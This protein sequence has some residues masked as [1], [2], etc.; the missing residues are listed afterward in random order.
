MIGTNFSGKGGLSVAHASLGSPGH[1]AQKVCAT[2]S[3]ALAHKILFVAMFAIF[4]P[5]AVVRRA[6]PTM[7]NRNGIRRSIFEEAKISASTASAY[8][9]M[10]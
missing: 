6:M 5:V 4:L 3:D 2:R 1:G 7:Q 10:G 8:A 9:F